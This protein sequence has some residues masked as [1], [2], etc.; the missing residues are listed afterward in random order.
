MYRS[1]SMV[2]CSSAMLSASWMCVIAREELSD[3][4]ESIRPSMCDNT[5][6]IT[7]S[8]VLHTCVY[9]FKPYDT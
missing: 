1:D 2:A 7:S 9:L 6:V 4:M 5:A 8:Y 3:E